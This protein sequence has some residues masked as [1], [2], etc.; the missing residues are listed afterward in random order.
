MT[1]TAANLM[2]FQGEYKSITVGVEVDGVA[3]DLTNVDSID[4]VMGVN[5]N[6]D[7]SLTKTLGDGIELTNAANGQFAIVL[8][9]VDT[10]SLTPGVYYHQATYDLN[11]QTVQAIA[12]TIR[13]RPAII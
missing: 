8:S 10:S 2:M 12:G 6:A 5:E 1:N 13:I 11:G 4:W 7:A 9:G 3:V